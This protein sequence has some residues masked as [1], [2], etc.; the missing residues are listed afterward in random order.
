MESIIPSTYYN[1]RFFQAVQSL[2]KLIYQLNVTIG[3]QTKENKAS[4][5]DANGVLKEYKD[6]AIPESHEFVLWL[7]A[8]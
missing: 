6:S 8:K 3:R 1:G 4:I 2:K 5:W 7:I